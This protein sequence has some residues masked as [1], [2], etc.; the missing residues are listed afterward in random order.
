MENSRR[1]R[2]IPQSLESQIT[3][4]SNRCDSRAHH[5]EPTTARGSYSKIPSS[6]RLTDRLTPVGAPSLADLRED[7]ASRFRQILDSN[8][9]DD[10]FA[11]LPPERQRHNNLSPLNSPLYSP[12][13]L[14]LFPF[15][16]SANSPSPYS[17]PQLLPTTL[18]PASLYATPEPP[19]IQQTMTFH[20]P[21]RGEHAS[22]TFDR[23]KP[24]ELIRFFEELEYLFN[25]TALD[26]EAE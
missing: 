21:A 14:P 5:L 17:S 13:E 26:D 15:G 18:F 10:L 8:L 12:S 23:T 24:R 25:R 20:M 1:S 22:P 19:I 6:T 2:N 11:E 4:N 3:K 9:E 7:L 16:Y